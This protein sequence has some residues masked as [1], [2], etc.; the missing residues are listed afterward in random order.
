MKVSSEKSSVLIA[1]R[2]REQIQGFRNALP[3]KRS[4]RLADPAMLEKLPKVQKRENELDQTLW[5]KELLAE[6]H[7]ED[8]RK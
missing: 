6:K 7:E 3:A 4:G 8:G 2:L 1:I 5:A